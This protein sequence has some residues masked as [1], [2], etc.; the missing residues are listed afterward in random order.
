MELDIFNV[1]IYIHIKPYPS[2]CQATRCISLNLIV[3]KSLSASL[4]GHILSGCL[5]AKTPQWDP[6]WECVLYNL[7]NVCV[8]LQPGIC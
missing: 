2:Q 8:V 3:G 7:V 5:E 1:C 6:H 4:T